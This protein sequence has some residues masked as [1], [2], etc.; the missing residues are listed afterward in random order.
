M[1]VVGFDGRP[2]LGMVAHPLEALVPCH[3][4]I[5]PPLH[6][7]LSRTANRS[8]SKPL[9]LA[10]KPPVTCLSPFLLERGEG[11]ELSLGLRLALCEMG[12]LQDSLVGRLR[13]E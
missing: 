4:C 10:S 5:V 11:A 2:A 6:A 13:M 8:S 12:I 3:C 1:I 7:G 9:G